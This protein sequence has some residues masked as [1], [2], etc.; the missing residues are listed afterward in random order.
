MSS[1]FSLSVSP[2]GIKNAFVG[3]F[4]GNLGYVMFSSL[5]S[6]GSN[7]CTEFKFE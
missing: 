1:V 3:G 7:L 6:L 4:I 5:E 2:G